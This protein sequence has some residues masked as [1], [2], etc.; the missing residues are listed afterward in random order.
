MLRRHFRAEGFSV[1]KRD[2]SIQNIST[3][4]CF[5]FPRCFWK[6]RFRNTRQPAGD[7]NLNVW[8][9]PGGGTDSLMHI[10]HVWCICSQKC[11]RNN[12]IDE[13][14]EMTEADFFDNVYMKVRSEEAYVVFQ[15]NV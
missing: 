8:H 12:Y 6:H 13:V 15:E 14:I 9:A 3:Y 7:Q 1:E 11:N 10:P 5:L 2:V 4:T